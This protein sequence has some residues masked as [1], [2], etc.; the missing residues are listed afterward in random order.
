[1]AK[2]TRES[3]W[4]AAQHPVSRRNVLA[5]AAALAA[6][7]L[8][9]NFVGAQ[10]TAE[11]LIAWWGSDDRHQKTLKI[12]KLFE[13]KHPGLKMNAQYGGLIGYQDKIATQFAGGNAPDVMQISDNREALVASGRLLQLDDA[14]SSGAINLSDANK[15]VI[16][17]IKVGGK[18]YSIPW[19]L[20]CG[21][22]FLDTKVFSDAGVEVPASDWTWDSYAEKAK[23]I[24]KATSGKV[25]GSCDIWAPAG[26]RSLYP[27]EFFLR[28]RG[29][30]TFTPDGQ[31]GFQQ[32]E[33]TEWFTFW[34][35]L[36]KAGGTPPAEITASEGGFETSPL[37]TGKAAMYPINSSIASSLQ[38]LTKNKLVCST[39]P[40][41]IGS[42]ALAGDK[43]GSFINSSMQVYINAATKHQDLAIQFLDFITNDPDAARIHLMARGAPLSAKIAQLIQPQVSPVEQS[44]ADVVLYVQQKAVPQI[45]S[46]PVTGG[47]VQD[48]MQR[49]H[50]AIAFGQDTVEGTVNKFFDEA[51]IILN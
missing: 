18:L 23:A 48:L 9:A 15:S 34:D 20:A 38:G 16:E 12:M 29:M 49:S 17:T 1:M 19:G 44:M 51:G 14:I 43:F 13:E 26:T 25:Y 36:R 24:T 50:Q 30:S 4:P 33:L 40:N 5:G 47:Q 8:L 7:P 3:I 28:Q 41:G 42:K 31:L 32:A 45:V 27:F 11:M 37:I 46:W 6:S 2:D 22:Y 39:F 35:E 21:C 10:E